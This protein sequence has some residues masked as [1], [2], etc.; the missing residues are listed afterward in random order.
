MKTVK[1][2][3]FRTETQSLVARVEAFENHEE[4]AAV[5]A[6]PHINSPIIFS[7]E[8]NGIEVAVRQFFFSD[9][10]LDANHVFEPNGNTQHAHA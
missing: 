7:T 3:H 6:A 1:F 2:F 9:I 5:L 10:Y 8:I 4:D